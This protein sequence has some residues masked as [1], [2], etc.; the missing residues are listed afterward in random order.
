MKYSGLSHHPPF[1]SF[2]NW[3]LSLLETP[4]VITRYKCIDKASLLDMKSVVAPI[5]PTFFSNWFYRSWR[6]FWTKA[7][8]PPGKIWY[9]WRNCCQ[10]VPMQRTAA[11]GHWFAPKNATVFLAKKSIKI[12]GCFSQPKYGS[13]NINSISFKKGRVRNPAGCCSGM[14]MLLCIVSIRTHTWYYYI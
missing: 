10:P 7:T 4:T 3:G 9:A 14:L 5:T 13:M 8:S 12:W 6:R 11:P 1:D 2:K